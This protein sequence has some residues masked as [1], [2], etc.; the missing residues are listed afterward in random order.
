MNKQVI[1]CVGSISRLC[2]AILRIAGSWDFN[3]FAI[4]LTI[5]KQLHKYIYA[6]NTIPA[7]NQLALRIVFVMGFARIVPVYCTGNAGRFRSMG[8][9]DIQSRTIGS[10]CIAIRNRD[11]LDRI[12]DRLATVVHILVFPF[13]RPA[14]IRAAARYSD[15][16]T[17]WYTVGKELY[18]NAFRA[19]AITVSIVIPQ[20]I[21]ID[22]TGFLVTG[23]CGFPLVLS[24][25][26]IQPTVDCAPGGRGEPVERICFYR[27]AVMGRGS[28]VVVVDQRIARRIRPA[29]RICNWD[30]CTDCPPNRKICD[31]TRPGIA[32]TS[33]HDFANLGAVTVDV[34]G[35]FI[36][37]RRVI[38]ISI[39]P[40]DR[41][42]KADALC[43][44]D[45]CIVI[46]ICCAFRVLGNVIDLC[47]PYNSIPVEVGREIVERVF[48][49]IIIAAGHSGLR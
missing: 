24:S 35:N 25:K 19:D 14:A 47:R 7:S 37:A 31:R 9:S 49:R 21:S 46:V 44:G 15:R 23:Q 34:H 4:G 11:H 3:W 22:I 41:K 18:F 1:P 29:E 12:H 28:G 10:C 26:V 17:R 48:P 5:D 32:V 42:I 38:I 13:D 43:H 2:I 27:C 45:R 8:Q 36:R 33:Q 40:I 30:C 6:L 39:V 16:L 20:D